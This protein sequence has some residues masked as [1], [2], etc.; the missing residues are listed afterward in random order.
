MV[1]TDPFAE[2]VTRGSSMVQREESLVPLP[3]WSSNNASA[4]SSAYVNPI[5]A[6]SSV[7][8]SEVR[9]CCVRVCVSLSLCVEILLILYVA[10]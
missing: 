6:F 5:P 9:M 2:T 8:I 7:H 10:M 3:Q 1:S 4:L